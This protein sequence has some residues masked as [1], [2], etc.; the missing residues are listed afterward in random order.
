MAHRRVRIEIETNHP[1][2][3]SSSLIVTS[4]VIYDFHFFTTKTDVSA[5][6][7]KACK[8]ITKRNREGLEKKNQMLPALK[9]A[10]IMRA[11]HDSRVA[12]GKTVS[13]RGGFSLPV[14]RDIIHRNGVPFL[15]NVS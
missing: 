9:S 1:F 15:C 2:V 11:L 5:R 7:G 13:M 10:E 4:W 3:F 14:K 6:C 12:V 8:E